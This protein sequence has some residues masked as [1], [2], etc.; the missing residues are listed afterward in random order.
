MC[1]RCGQPIHN[2]PAPGGTACWV[3]DATG[4]DVCGVAGGNERHQP[5]EGGE[6]YDPA[7]APARCPVCTGPAA[8]VGLIMM[9]NGRTSQEMWRWDCPNGHTVL[10]DYTDQ[11]GD[12][13]EPRAE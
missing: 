9:D 4:G 1:V 7:A 8:Y 6:H 5:D 10:A 12:D 13:L 3:D 11:M 2:E